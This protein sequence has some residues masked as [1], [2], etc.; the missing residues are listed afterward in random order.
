[1]RFPTP[2]RHGTFLRRYKRFFA[3]VRLGEAEVI[4]HVPNTGSLLSCLH[5]GLGCVV[6]E[7]D[8]PKRKLRATLHFLET[9]TGWVGVN[10]GVP[11]RLVVDS[12]RTHPE[13]AQYRVAKPEYKI[14]AETRL[15][16]V[17]APSDEDL[18]A[19]RDLHYV[20]VKSVTY[21]ADGVALFPD[22]VTARGQK[23]LRELMALKAL[24]A[25]AE[26]LFVVQRADVRAFAP[27]DAID[28]TYGRL[29]RE[30]VRAGVRVR[31]LACVIDPLVGVELR[32]DE[33][34]V[35]LN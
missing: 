34:P 13:W 20:E 1:M 35:L 29:L 25:K 26:L 7:T 14:N 19:K 22:A 21:A 12:W 31:A 27:A 6:T 15:D 3:D 11:N 33:L 5:A 2:A 4:A 17:L 8:D 9:P 30:A 16:L 10:T 28:P 32:L 23:H 18:A 24:G